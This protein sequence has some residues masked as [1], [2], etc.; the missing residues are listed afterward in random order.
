[1]SNIR[2]KDLSTEATSLGTDDFIP[3]DGNTSGTRK[4][5]KEN[6]GTTLEIPEVGSQPNQTPL[7]LHL[8][9]LAYADADSV[10]VAELQVE[11]T[12]GTGTTEALTVTDGTDTKFLVRE[13]GRLG[14]N[15]AS[16][17]QDIH[18]TGA[19]P[20]IRL[21]DTS[22]GGSSEIEALNGSLVI[23]SDIGDA[24]AGSFIIFKVDGSETA[25]ID[26]AGRLGVNQTSPTA[27]LQVD[28]PA[29]DQSGAA[30]IKA[31][32]TAYGTNKA[33]HG[34]MNTSSSTKSLLYL[35][36]GSGSVLDVKGD[37]TVALS[38]AIDFGSGANTTLSD[39]ERGS[40]T[41]TDQ[42]GAGLT[43]AADSGTY[44]KIGGQV[45]VWCQVQ[46]PTTS[47]TSQA[48]IGGLPF[49]IGG[50]VSDRAGGIAAY[51]T[52]VGVLTVLGDNSVAK[53]RFFKDGRTAATNA[54][55]SGKHVWF[56]ITYDVS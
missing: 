41:A 46:Y 37:G 31:V 8:G 36:N 15:T 19:D 33:F 26:S 14:V 6:L 20:T 54:D 34:Y 13:D 32:G 35:E 56:S 23:G 25:R 3:V 5:S 9:S 47:D 38:G 24:V 10:S 17:A 42:S 43:L 50:S 27:Q 11:S 40:V 51:T 30:A 45:T 16:P 52:H 53:V 7:N 55:L 39:Y 48:V 12:T 21:Q 28:Q 2:I 1:M 49:A 4:I 29:S 44:I 22:A 18:I